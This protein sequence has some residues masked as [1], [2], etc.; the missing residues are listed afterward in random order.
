MQ[1][2]G[3]GG[4]VD[5]CSQMSAHARSRPVSRAASAAMAMAW[6]DR[7]LPKLWEASSTPDGVLARVSRAWW[8]VIVASGASVRLASRPGIGLV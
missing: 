6:S 4:T 2:S 7:A 5:E 3:K 8:T 1:R